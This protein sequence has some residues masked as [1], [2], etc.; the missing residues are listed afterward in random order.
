MDNTTKTGYGHTHND[1]SRVGA[2]IAEQ[3]AAAE[4]ER[5]AAMDA[6]AAALRA[7]AEAARSA[8]AAEQAAVLDRLRTQRQA[9]QAAEETLLKAEARE[10][11][12]GTDASFEADWPAI[13]ARLQ[14]D[15]IVEE[16]RREQLDRQRMRQEF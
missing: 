5:R 11:Y 8:R 16:Q 14:A 1:L 4:Q 6:A 15:K 2:D 12:Q 10:H 3:K 9:A 13:R 7:D